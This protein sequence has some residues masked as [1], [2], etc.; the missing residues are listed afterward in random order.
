MIS[1][2][3]YLQAYHNLPFYSEY[4]DNIDNDRQTIRD[5]NRELIRKYP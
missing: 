5:Y 3:E 2:E 4:Y 1:L